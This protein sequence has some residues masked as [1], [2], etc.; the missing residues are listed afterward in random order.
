MLLLTQIQGIQFLIKE[1]LI[2]VDIP[3]TSA[4]SNSDGTIPKWIKNNAGW[5]ADDSIDDQ[6][7]IQGIQFLI[8]QGILQ[9][10]EK[11]SQSSNSNEIPSWIKNNAGWWAN[12]S[13]DDQTFIQGIQYLIKNG[14]IV[15]T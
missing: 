5:W 2:V 11:T 6:T 10:Q 14:V 1:N 3:E 9:V 7:F 13:I 4:T 8:K 12:D 15:T